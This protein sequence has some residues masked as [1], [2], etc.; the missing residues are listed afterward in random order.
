ML[1]CVLKVGCMQLE[2]SKVAAN[3][4]GS[5]RDTCSTIAAGEGLENNIKNSLRHQHKAACRSHLP[6]CPAELAQAYFPLQAAPGP[7]LT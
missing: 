3:D 1:E 5:T 2:T 7:Q 6:L 4:C